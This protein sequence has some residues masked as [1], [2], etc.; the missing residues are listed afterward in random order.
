TPREPACAAVTT[1]GVSGTNVHVVLGQ[2]PRPTEEETPRQ[3]RYETTITPTIIPLSSATPGGLRENIKALLREISQPGKEN[4]RLEDIAYTLSVGRKHYRYR[5]ADVVDSKETLVKSL[6]KALAAPQTGET[7]AAE[8][9]KMVYIFSDHENLPEE[10]PRSLGEAHPQY[11]KEYTRLLDMSPTPH[12]HGVK[13][14]AAQYANY[15]L[16]EAIG[17][18]TPHIM[19]IGIGTILRQVIANE[20]TLQEGLQKATEY[21]PEEIKELDDRVEKL[22]RRETETVLYVDMGPGS[23]IAEKL[24]EKETPQGSHRT[25][26]IPANA[27]GKNIAQQQEEFITQLYRAGNDLDWKQYYKERESRRIELPTYRFQK[28]RCWLREAPRKEEEPGKTAETTQLKENATEI[29]RIIAANWQEVL[30]IKQYSLDDDFFEL[31]GDSLKATKVILKLNK[32]FKI[33]LDF[34]DMFDFPTIRTMGDYINEQ[35][36]TPQRIAHIWK[37]VL[38]VEKVETADNFFELGGHS[39]LASQVLNGIAKEFQLKLDFEDF[40]IHPTLE[41]LAQLVNNRLN[42]EKNSAYKGIEIAEKREYYPLSPAQKRLYILQRIDEASIAYN[43][44]QIVR[45]EG[46]LERKKFQEAITKLAE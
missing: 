12:Q 31:G 11:R 13:D 27:T 10:I 38:K 43:E 9:K 23:I 44:I 34:E 33:R 7:P 42:K 41:A 14:I 18:T 30:E 36:G 4:I 6:E 40:F 37:K 45:L 29:H 16:L 8:I 15:K 26:T 35:M 17:I 28:T 39:L 22:I 1:L 32:E 2:P 20:I 46:K 5:Y 24:K 3:D 19:K 25:Y 21:K